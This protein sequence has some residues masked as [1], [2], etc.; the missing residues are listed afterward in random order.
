MCQKDEK[1][2]V[3]VNTIVWSWILNALASGWK[4]ENWTSYPP[5][6]ECGSESKLK[7]WSEDINWDIKKM[8]H[9]TGLYKK[10]LS[11]TVKGLR[12]YPI[13]KLAC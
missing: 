8:L 7:T 3:L 1:L 12:V 4:V 10:E 5:I 11:E 6:I 13:C 9:G 2:K